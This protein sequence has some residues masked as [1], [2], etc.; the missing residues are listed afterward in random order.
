MKDRGEGTPGG[1]SQSNRLKIIFSQSETLKRRG[2]VL[3]LLTYI[4]K[5]SVHE[6]LW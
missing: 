5:A 2:G 1:V 4:L 3:R 6:S